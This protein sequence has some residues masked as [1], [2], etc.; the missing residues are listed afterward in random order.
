MILCYIAVCTIPILLSYLGQRFQLETHRRVGFVVSV[1]A[2][3]A[4]GRGF[5]RLP[6]HTKDS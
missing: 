1:S 2:S 5:V 4:I 6:G 3:H